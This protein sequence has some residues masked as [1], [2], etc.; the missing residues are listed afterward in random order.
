MNY[1]FYVIS[2][3]VLLIIQTV[4]LA[5]LHLFHYSYDF[6][7]VLVLYLG[8]FRPISEGLPMSVFLGIF[9]DGISGG[10]FWVY[11]TTYVWYF[12]FM[13][14]LIQYLHAGS[15]VLLPFALSIGV[16]LENLFLM[17]VFTGGSGEPISIKSMHIIAYQMIWAFFTGPIWMFLLKKIHKKVLVYS[18]AGDQS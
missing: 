18:S 3:F 10:P 13:R 14:W 4:I 11:T 7:L 8:L 1:F 9:M 6:L 5:D 15:M 12:I 2:S 16:F 17:I